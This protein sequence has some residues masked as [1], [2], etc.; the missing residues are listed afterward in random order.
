MRDHLEH[1][2][3]FLNINLGT[4]EETSEIYA[5]TLSEESMV[6]RIEDSTMGLF[7]PPTE[8]SVD[9]ELNDLE[10]SYKNEACDPRCTENT[11]SELLFILV[12]SIGG[13]VLVVISLVLLILLII[14]CNKKKKLGKLYQS[15]IVNNKST[16]IYDPKMM[17]PKIG[18][19]FNH[20]RATLIVMTDQ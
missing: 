19:L 8:N 12:V 16:E 9:V 4:K 17:H 2:K 5:S 14:E 11:V 10:P 15:A 7:E 20:I 3:E 6:N 18:H 13:G 1:F